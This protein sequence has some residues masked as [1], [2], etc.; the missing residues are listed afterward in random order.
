MTSLSPHPI[1]SS[2]WKCWGWMDVRIGSIRLSYLD[3]RW[4]YWPWTSECG[5]DK[6][7]Q[8]NYEG[9]AEDLLRKMTDPSGLFNER[10]TPDVILFEAHF[11]MDRTAWV[12]D[13]VSSWIAP[14]WHGRVLLMTVKPNN[15]VPWERYVSGAAVQ[16]AHLAARPGI[17]WEYFDDSHS[18]MM[19]QTGE[20]GGLS[21][22]MHERCNTNGK[23]VCGLTN[24]MTVHGLMSFL[25][26]QPPLGWSGT[27]KIKRMPVDGDIRCALRLPTNATASEAEASASSE[28]RFCLQVR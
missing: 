5:P 11:G 20:S 4:L 10:A 22:H 9:R 14:N 28:M 13:K 3:W 19:L 8:C 2:F 24:E 18:T 1:Q 21:Q 26:R 27:E 6:Q 7:I 23:H 17:R 15:M 16:S 12:F 25:L